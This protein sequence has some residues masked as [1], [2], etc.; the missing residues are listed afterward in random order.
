MSGSNWKII[1]FFVL[2]FAGSQNVLVAQCG[3]TTFLGNDTSICVN[4]SLTLS[5]PP[6][7]ISFLWNTSSTT[8]NINVSNPGTYWCKATK[9]DTTNLVTNGDFEAG[10]T[11]FTTGHTYGTGGS[12][13]LLSAAGQYAISTNS[14]LTHIN[15]PSCTDHTSG[16][17][18]YMIVNGSSTAN[19][20]VWCQTITVLPNTTYY[21]SAWITSVVSNSPAILSFKVNNVSL[22][23][24][25]NVSSL[26]CNWQNYFQTWTSGATTTSATIC[27]TNQN[28]AS[29]GNDFALDDISFRPKCESIDTILI[30]S[31][32]TPNVNLGPDTTICNGDTIQVDAT[33]TT[34]STYIW[35]SGD[36][37]PLINVVSDSA[38]SVTITRGNCTSIETKNITVI[39]SPIVNLGSDTI[40]CAGAT[41][42]LS[43]S[44]TSA[45]Y[46]WST[47][48]TSNTIIAS[49]D[50]SYWGTASNMCG[51]DSDTI[52]VTLDS[53]LI[54]D[55]GPD[56]IL[57]SGNTLSLNSNVTGRSYHWNNGSTSNTTLV[58]SPYTYMLTVSNACGDFSDTILVQYDTSPQTYLGVDSIYCITNLQTLSTAWSRSTFLW[59]TGSTDSAIIA[60]TTG[61]YSV[62]VINLCGHDNDTISLIYDSPILFNLGLDTILC[63]GDSLILQAPDTTNNYIWE[64]GTT[65]PLRTI[66]SPGLYSI[67]TSNVCG[68]FSDT[69]RVSRV[70]KASINQNLLDTAI[71]I[72]QSF[73]K[74]IDLDVADQIIWNDGDTNFQKTF[75]AP[76]LYI[77]YLT[78][79]CGT[80]SDSF[81]LTVDTPVVASLAP[82]TI[83]C[84]GD[85][86]TR[87][88]NFPN[89]TY[90]WTDGST[91]N[92]NEFREP[93]QYGVVITSPGN[94]ETTTSFILEPCDAGLYIPTAFTPQSGDDLNN[95]FQIFSDGTS[96][97][98]IVIY[99]RW[100]LEVFE[101]LDIKNSWDGRI[102][103]KPAAAGIYSYRIWYN[104]GYTTDSKVLYG[105]VTLIR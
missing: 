32:P 63:E 101:S 20:T 10:N 29:G 61:L 97:F 98:R 81:Q 37:L 2:I 85:I 31:L 35:A 54:V 83:I 66:N 17:G 46:L 72:Q 96:K 44:A 50:T 48:Q 9:M 79:I 7:Y 80:V 75:F 99:D 60:D 74:G 55:I 88:F 4:E 16:T 19:L 58:S 91:S 103:G 87:S 43:M 24:N 47:S 38:L 36:T 90:L 27:I 22:G 21:F 100:G 86:V 77:Y 28:T 102:N 84:Y 82:D 26:T 30:S 1:G 71:C 95:T 69:L 6:G 51:S 23:P 8:A 104:P 14:N 5:A 53:S 73:T 105:Q 39:D 34:N 94:C 67:S 13:G 93:G 12:W 64:N 11:G 62:Q 40:L 45:T 33:D 78:N 25:H 68:F 52:S 57:C 49:Q 41:I 59:N 18:K 65:N 92:A 15:F 89:H 3:N 42:P 76:D 70:T 56:T